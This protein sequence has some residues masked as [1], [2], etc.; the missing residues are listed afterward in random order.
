[1]LSDVV[2]SLKAKPGSEERLQQMLEALIAP[3][4]AETGCVDYDLHRSFEDPGSFVFHEN[5]ENREV[6]ER[7]MESPHLRAFNDAQGEVTE[8]WSLFLGE[9]I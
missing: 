2:A 9:R 7:H 4:R 6:W 3:T 1:M 5:W 8:S